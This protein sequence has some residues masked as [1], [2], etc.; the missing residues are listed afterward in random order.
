M[1]ERNLLFSISG[2]HGRSVEVWKEKLL[3]LECQIEKECLCFDSSDDEYSTLS[4]CMK[5]LSKFD[6]GI[7]SKLKY[8]QQEPPK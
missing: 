2:H 5:C 1:S 4:F 6:K 7:K 3:C 8:W